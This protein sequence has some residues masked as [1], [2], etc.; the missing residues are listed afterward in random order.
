MSSVC[1][2]VCV[3]VCTILDFSRWDNFRTHWIR[4]LK[5][6]AIYSLC[7][8][9]LALNR[10]FNVDGLT[11]IICV[12]C[13]WKLCME[14]TF[15]RIQLK[16]NTWSVGPMFIPPTQKP[17]KILTLAILVRFRWNF[18]G[19]SNF[20]CGPPKQHLSTLI[21]SWT[22]AIFRFLALI[23]PYSLQLLTPYLIAALTA[24]YSSLLLTW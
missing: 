4:K 1:V 18:V 9:L 14:V 6:F 8:M 11:S 15:W 12:R 24:P 17:P 21:P 3:C 2:S 10:R 20:G 22:T 23:T 13:W 5:P 16:R 7:K 19:K